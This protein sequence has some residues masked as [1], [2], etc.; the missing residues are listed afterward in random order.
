MIFQFALFKL[1]KKTQKKQTKKNPTHTREISYSV[2][3]I[4]LFHF[5]IIVL[6]LFTLFH[7]IAELC[8]M[9]CIYIYD[10]NHWRGDV[11]LL[12]VILKM[13]QFLSFTLG[14]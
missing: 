11:L 9:Y 14:E 10:K 13:K 4:I 5:E 2:L 3:F 8:F 7:E 12:I 6:I 1:K